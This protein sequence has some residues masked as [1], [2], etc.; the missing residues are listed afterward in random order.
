MESPLRLEFL[1]GWQARLGQVP[2]TGFASS[3]VQ[4]L[5]CYLAVTGRPQLRNTL[6]TLLWGELPDADAAN[7]LRQA[8]NNL[9]R[10]L[11]PYLE[12]TR[13]TVA[14]NTASA[15]WLDVAHFESML[16]AGLSTSTT[17]RLSE[18]V[19]LYRGDFLEGFN[20]RAAPEFDEWALVQ[21]ERLRALA[22]RALFQLAAEQGAR[23]EWLAAIDSITRLLTLDPW[24]EEVHQQLMLFLARSGQRSAA[25][26]QYQTCQRILAEELGV[27]PLPETTALYERIRTAPATR[28]TPPVPSVTFVGRDDERA[29]LARRLADPACRL[30]TIVGPGGIGKTRLALQAAQDAAL[31]LLH[32]AAV[33]PLAAVTSADFL[34]SAIASELNLSFQGADEPRTQ[35]LNYLREKELLIALDNF[36]HLIEDG[37]QLLVDLLQNAPDVQLLVTSREHLRLQ[38]EWL[39]ELD[40]LRVPADESAEAVASYSAIQLFL[41]RAQQVSAGFTLAHDHE[42]ERAVIRV[43]RLVEGLPLGIELAAAWT[44]VLSCQEIA[45]EIEHSL[46]FLETSLRDVPE[47]HRSLRAVV[48]HSWQALSPEERDVLSRLSIFRGGFDRAAAQQVAG[49]SSPLLLAL[50]NKSL[51]RGITRLVGSQ[52]FELHEFIRQYAADQLA[53]EPEETRQA[54]DR[55]AAYYAS[56]LQNQAQRL[57]GREQQ[58]ALGAIG[59]EIDNVRAGW[60][61]AVAHRN[62][63][64]LGQSLESLAL[65]YEIRGWFQEGEDVF[66]QAATALAGSDIA[67]DEAT[68]ILLAHVLARQAVFDFRFSRYEHAT[69]LLDRSLDLA[70]SLGDTAGIVFALNTL[71]TVASSRARYTE[72]QQRVQESLQLARSLDDWP[73]MAHALNILGNAAYYQGDYGVAQQRHQESLALRRRTDD[74][75]GIAISLNNLANATWELGRHEEAMGFYEASMQIH[76]ELGYR[77]GMANTGVNLADAARILGDYA[78]ARAHLRTSL[79]LFREM[80]ERQGV[81]HTLH[82]LGSVAA[83]LGELS[84]AQPHLEEGLALFR[85]IGSREGIAFSLTTLGRV[86]GARG[87][88]CAA[89]E[90]LREG[91]MTALAIQSLPVAL[92]AITDLAILLAREDVSEASERAVAYLTLALIHPASDQETRDRATRVLIDLKA[93]L[94]PEQFTAARERGRADTLEAI[95][96]QMAGQ[97]Q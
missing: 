42:E 1:G 47:R 49:A 6:A 23:A 30:I 58:A 84:Q 15:Y 66:G 32:G 19:T 55:H 96:A 57:T 20:V 44:P 69:D 88:R 45:R 36:E 71:A 51:L 37:T 73:G 35:L 93:R 3:K 52:R 61:W 76:T 91:L 43:C 7:N 75:R 12:I 63:A 40:G 81:A 83:T 68:C 29:T 87:D 77:Y 25:L 41:Q 59:M 11:D 86:V 85:E 4:A 28:T 74:L 79:A 18:A 2:V 72:A 54:S 80:G 90:Y 62:V 26:A 70:R 27:E 53:A 39:L 89:Q 10:L 21:R 13:Q 92:V 56:F 94:L 34:V 33:V 78:Q 14:I 5:L 60:L 48:A 16:A 95:L 31:R 46:R 65:F 50:V 17:E 38:G 24:R 97:T 64:E 9:R 8:L 67:G 22:V 82:M